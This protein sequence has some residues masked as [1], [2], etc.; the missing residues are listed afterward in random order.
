MSPLVYADHHATTPLVPE[1]LEAMLPWLGRPAN[2]SSVHAEGRAARLAVEEAREAVAAAIGARPAEIVFTSGGTESDNLAV[3]GAAR[4]VRTRTGRARVVVTAAEHAAVREAALGLVAEGFEVET[5]PVDA[6]GLPLPHTPGPAAA[7][8]S[9]I[10]ASNET[11]A[12]DEALP[13]LAAAWHES[14]ALVHTDAVQAVGKLPVDVERLGV[15]LLSLAGHKLGGPRGAGA[16]YV[17]RGTALRPLVSGGGQEKGRRSGT[18]NVPAIVGLGAAITRAVAA[19]EAEGRRLA[20]LRDRLEAGLLRACPGARVNAAPAARLPTASS[21][22]FP[23][24]DAETLLAAL[25]LEGI[26]ASSGSACASG[27]TAPSRVLLACGLTAGEAR[28]TVRFSFGWTTTDADV[29]RLL[30]V[31]P[32]LATRVRAALSA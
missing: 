24:T 9:M 25:D 28:S 7:L 6:N 12:I 13:A 29:A 10:L 22:L 31:V 18:E 1:A 8:V 19:L 11:G 23:G 17:R 27:T 4:E 30:E 21:V 14:G 15:D 20:L 32:R 16:L 2:P 5:L 3:R 26:A